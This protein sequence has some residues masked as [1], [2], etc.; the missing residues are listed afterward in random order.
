MYTPALCCIVQVTWSHLCVWPI[1]SPFFN[2]AVAS[3]TFPDSTYVL[4]P[5]VHLYLIL[6]VMW[7]LLPRSL[8]DL[9]LAVLHYRKSIQHYR[10]YFL[11][12]PKLFIYHYRKLH[13]LISQAMY[14]ISENLTLI[15]LPLARL[16][17]LPPAHRGE[18]EVGF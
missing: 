11:L 17:L 15:P 5:A 7:L 18:V 13:Q 14:S 2:C 8:H 16:Y 1:R 10:K 3:L 12:I 6:C 9:C 4:I